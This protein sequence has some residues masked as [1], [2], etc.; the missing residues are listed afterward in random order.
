MKGRKKK[1][2]CA[3][4]ETLHFLLSSV[5]ELKNHFSQTDVKVRDGH[6]TFVSM[7]KP[8][9]K[10]RVASTLRDQ[11]QRFV[12]GNLSAGLQDHRFL[13]SSTD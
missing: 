6:P 9:A 11:E 2:C 13:P 7:I 12:L 5:S 8:G 1:T 3:C 10:Q 4:T